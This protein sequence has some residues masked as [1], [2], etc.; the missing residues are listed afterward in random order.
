MPRTGFSPITVVRRQEVEESRAIR[1]ARQRLR[2]T[3]EFLRVARL[4]RVQHQRW[5]R[6]ILNE[7]RLVQ[8]VAEIGNVVDVRHVGLRD[9]LD[10]RHNF[11]Q[12]GAHESD[13]RV[14][15]G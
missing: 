7:L 1:R 8:A 2:S 3:R 14:R 9:E 5:Q 15:L 10:V 4:Q 12:H 13:D 11:V 6:K